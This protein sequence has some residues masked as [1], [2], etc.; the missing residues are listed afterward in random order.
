MRA[1]TFAVIALICSA[2]GKES[3]S[4]PAQKSDPPKPSVTPAPSPTSLKPW[5]VK[6]R[7]D[8]YFSRGRRATD[9]ASGSIDIVTTFEQ[10]PT[11]YYKTLG[12][13]PPPMVL[14]VFCSWNAE[15]LQGLREGDEPI[16]YANAWG[17]K[18][19]YQELPEYPSNWMSLVRGVEVWDV[20]GVPRGHQR[21]N[22]WNVRLGDQELLINMSQWTI[23][24][25]C[26]RPLTDLNSEASVDFR[27]GCE[28]TQKRGAKIG[29]AGEHPPEI[30]ICTGDVPIPGMFAQPFE[31]K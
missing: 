14:S 10:E 11:D 4:E 13:T 5:G 27:K 29:M 31:T 2:C 7:C 19:I 3:S 16:H 21:E 6:R 30:G 17:C 20:S 8:V 1:T 23:T 22:S 26:P 25:R 12:R 9:R 15:E 24:L 28:V 18:V